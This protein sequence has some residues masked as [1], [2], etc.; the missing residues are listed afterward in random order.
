MTV[1]LVIF[2]SMD[3]GINVSMYGSSMN[4]DAKCIELFQ[5]KLVN[6]MASICSVCLARGSDVGN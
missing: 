3:E 4:K 6:S 5:Q 2:M 1:V